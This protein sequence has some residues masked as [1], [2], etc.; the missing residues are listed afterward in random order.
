[1]PKFELDIP[2]K[3]SPD[4][5]RAR[6]GAATGKIE[7]SYGATCSWENDRLLHVSRKGFDAH[8]TIEPARVHVDMNLG[9]LLV[10]LAGAIKTGL[11]KE[12]SGLLTS[13]SGDAEPPPG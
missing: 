11:S 12:L 9:F 4:D 3:L 2:H 1:M 5:V 7:A 10:P 6:L 8:V 13:G